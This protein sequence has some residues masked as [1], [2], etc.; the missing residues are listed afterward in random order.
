MLK[1][2]PIINFGGNE[3]GRPTVFGWVDTIPEQGK[4]VTL[5]NARM[6][7]VWSNCGGIFGMAAHGPKE[8]C[9][10]TS[11]VK[12]AIDVTRQ[13]IAVSDDAA[14]AIEGWPVA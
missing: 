13:A 6:I 5:H 8:G 14:E 7:L 12:W 1:R 2:I 3:N 9:K 11:S 4:P 10:I